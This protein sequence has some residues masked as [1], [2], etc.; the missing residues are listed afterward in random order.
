MKRLM[1]NY[2]GQSTVEYVL[3]LATV[4]FIVGLVMRSPLF[5][6][7]LG[8]DSSFFTALKERMEYSYR[9]AHEPLNGVDPAGSGRDDSPYANVRSHTSYAADDGSSRFAGNTTPYP[10]P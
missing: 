9:Y 7:L 10:G 5:A 8:E 4:M 1:R 3:L 2:L 6:E